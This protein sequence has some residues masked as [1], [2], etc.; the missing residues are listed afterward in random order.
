[1]FPGHQLLLKF[2]D[3]IAVLPEL[4][5]DPCLMGIV[6]GWAVAT[7]AILACVNGRGRLRASC[8]IA[9]LEPQCWQ[10]RGHQTFVKVPLSF[11]LRSRRWPY[12]ATPANHVV[13]GLGLGTSAEHKN[14]FTLAT[15]SDTMKRQTARDEIKLLPGGL[16]VI[17][18]GVRTPGESEEPPDINLGCGIRH[19][20]SHHELFRVSRCRF[21]I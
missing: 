15:L 7:R 10:H 8:S 4:Q 13:D 20:C 19:P 1:M 9:N 21:Y 11:G 2:V 12:N 18:K 5:C 3:N 14:I 16:D 6:S 17:S